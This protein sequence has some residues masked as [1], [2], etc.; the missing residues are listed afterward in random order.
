[1]TYAVL[2]E[3]GD[4]DAELLAAEI[5]RRD[6]A[7]ALVWADELLLDSR[8]THRVGPDGVEAELRCARG[9][10]FDAA[11]LRGV[12]C[13]IEQALPP[14]FATAAEADRE[15]AAIESQALLLSWLAGLPCPVLNRPSPRGLSGP[16]LAPLEW[17]P[18]AAAHG[19]RSRATRL[20]SGDGPPA[21]G[22]EPVEGH[23]GLWG[24]PVPGPAEWLLVVGERVALGEPGAEGESGYVALARGA[25][26]QLLGV[27][28]SPPNGG[29]GERTFLG[30]TARPA[31]GPAGAAAVAELIAGAS[32]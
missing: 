19:L 10:R 22:W 4:A 30:A 17:L 29:R 27:Q 13:R 32:R 1:V 31:L 6:P 8:F 16:G 21:P 18:L 26:C 12:A 28:V 5:E 24:E 2:A 15:Y 7:V 23:P 20:P 9:R 25:G 3:R 14:Q 11:S